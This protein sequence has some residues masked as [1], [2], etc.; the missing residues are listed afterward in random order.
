MLATAIQLVFARVNQ[1][2]AE[3]IL[4]QTYI[5]TVITVIN[6]LIAVLS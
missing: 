5:R 4:I 2:P 6:N 3:F 1:R